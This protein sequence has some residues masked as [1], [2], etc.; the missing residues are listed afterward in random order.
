[1]FSNDN[2][3]FQAL[4]LEV[5]PGI[6]HPLG[7]AGGFVQDGVEYLYAGPGDENIMYLTSDYW[8]T[9]ETIQYQLI[10]DAGVYWIYPDNDGTDRLYSIETALSYS[11]DGGERWHRCGS[12]NSNSFWN[13]FG[14]WPSGGTNNFSLDPR[15]DGKFFFT[16]TSEGLIYNLTPDCSKLKKVFTSSGFT[17]HF[18][19]AV[20]RHPE[21]PDIVYAGTANGFFVSFNNGDTWGEVNDGLLGAQTIYS[22][23]VDP[24]DPDTVYAATPYGIFRLE[25][26]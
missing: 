5:D 20:V 6:M 1:M 22:L 25:G 13:G 17:N 19:T 12:G 26:K 7:M 3:P 11:N 8:E 14:M 21:N 18:T 15:E 2:G 4:P 24:N 23:A 9:W 16:T 10:G